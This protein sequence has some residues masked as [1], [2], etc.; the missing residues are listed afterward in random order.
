MDRKIVP[1][2][3]GRPI[4]VLIDDRER[5]CSAAA[6]MEALSDFS[7]TY[8]RLELGDYQVD[9]KLLVERKT[10]RDFVASIEDGRIF[11]QAWRMAGGEWQP[12]LILE[13][14][15]STLNGCA[16]R[17]EAI[18]GALLTVSLIWGIPVLRSLDG[19]ETAKL[20]LFAARQ[21]RR[22][23]GGIVFR[24]GRR[25]RGKRQAQLR[26][27]QGL[28]GVGPRRAQALLAKFQNVEAVMIADEAA[29]MEIDS[30]ANKIAQ[31]IRWAVSEV[32]IPYK[33]ERFL[34]R[35]PHQNPDSQGLACL[36]SPSSL[37][38]GFFLINRDKGDSR[39]GPD[40]VVPR[41]SAARPEA[42]RPLP[43]KPIP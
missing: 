12:L 20:I 26:I 10:L 42:K 23:A 37:F 34:L 14:R 5:G 7:C 13:G 36:S 35:A 8:Q 18:Q 21:I 15:A 39:D 33:A 6:E 27:L 11:R 24:P 32:Q 9:G 31:R 17:R 19:T 3:R 22:A 4:T 38:I 41:S 16:M 25:P 2:D 1:E 29:L 40:A 43:S 28:P 30:I